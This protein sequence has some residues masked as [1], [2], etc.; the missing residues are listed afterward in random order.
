MII[1][2]PEMAAWAVQTI[3]EEMAEV[4]YE[5]VLDEKGRIRWI[6]SEPE[7]PVVFTTEPETSFWQ[8]FYV[9]FMRMLPI[10][11]QL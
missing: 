7:E 10:E 2:S 9:G 8:R 11:S 4:A 3:H 5:V 6:D 1:E